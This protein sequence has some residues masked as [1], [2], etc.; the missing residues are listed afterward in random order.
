M[1]LAETGLLPGD[2]CADFEEET[3]IA[4]LICLATDR[5]ERA[6]EVLDVSGKGIPSAIL[7]ASKAMDHHE[8]F[9]ME[10]NSMSS[11]TFWA[12]ALYNPRAKA[13][14]AFFYYG[15]PADEFLQFFEVFQS[16]TWD[17]EVPAH[18][19]LGFITESNQGLCGPISN[20]NPQRVPR[21]MIED[22]FA[23]TECE[24]VDPEYFSERFDDYYAEFAAAD[25]GN[26]A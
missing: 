6:S 9:S 1:T 21:S 26:P 15:E 14:I 2:V 20:F 12:G 22:A 23:K 8:I 5:R 19:I 10:E 7:K 24:R 25:G 16:A 13:G 17:A 4:A 3:L 18:L 11:T